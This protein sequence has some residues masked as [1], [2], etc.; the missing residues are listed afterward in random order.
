[1]SLLFYL[2]LY[3]CVFLF[4]LALD[5]ASPVITLDSESEVGSSDRDNWTSEDGEILISPYIVVDKYKQLKTVS[6]MSTLSVRLA[7]ESF[8]GKETMRNCTVRGT[9]EHDALPAKKLSDLKRF[10]QHVFSGCSQPEFE[11]AWKNCIDAIGQS[12][13]S[14][15]K[16]TFF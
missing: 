10:L 13:N 16:K 8:F 15:R 2:A 11:V 14:L 5:E 9:R 3:L 7:K 1:M 6:R 12:C 4:V